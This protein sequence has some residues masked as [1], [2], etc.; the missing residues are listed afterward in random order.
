MREIDFDALQKSLELFVYEKSENGRENGREMVGNVYGNC[1]WMR[2]HRFAR[3]LS[4]A[5]RHSYSKRY[6][7]APGCTPDGRLL[8]NF[9]GRRNEI[10]FVRVYC[11]NLEIN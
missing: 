5:R 6:E 8:I 2:A 4:T 9:Q 10:D 1:E 7:E 11:L 3:A